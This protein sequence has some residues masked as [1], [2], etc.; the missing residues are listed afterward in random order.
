MMTS[1]ITFCL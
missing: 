1:P